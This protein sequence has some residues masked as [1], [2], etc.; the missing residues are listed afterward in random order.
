LW[1]T[2]KRAIDDD[3]ISRIGR[4]TP[5]GTDQQIRQ[6]IRE[7]PLPTAGSFPVGITAG[8]DGNL[9]FTELGTNQI[10]RI[11]PAGVVTEFRIPTAGGGPYGITA[12]PDSNLWFTEAIAN[13]I[14]RLV[15]GVKVVPAAPTV[16]RTNPEANNVVAGNPFTFRVTLQDPFGNTA[17]GFR[18]MLHFSSS[19]PQAVLPA[20]YTFTEADAGQH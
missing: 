15:P 2:E 17:T 13:K 4:I 1:F 19:D 8:P 14:G 3:T 12:G 7:F 9:W 5:A 10:G 16:L 20:D 6:S 18:G 11:T